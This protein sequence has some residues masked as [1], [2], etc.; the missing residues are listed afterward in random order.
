MMIKTANQIALFPKNVPYVPVDNNWA[1]LANRIITSMEP[2][3]DVTPLVI[4]IPPD[5]FNI[6]RIQVVSSDKKAQIV[7]SSSKID[8][9]VEE[10]TLDNA[11]KDYFAPLIELLGIEV[12]RIGV[13]KHF[14]GIQFSDTQIK[15]LFGKAVTWS[16]V[17]LEITQKTVENKKIDTYQVVKL[18]IKSIEK[19]GSCNVSIDINNI[20]NED[21]SFNKETTIDLLNHYASLAN[22]EQ[23][24]KILGLELYE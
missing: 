19:N 21:I 10:L 15:T 3:K 17:N 18:L 11:R 23:A 5:E 13:I 14:Q 16:D 4:P 20:P 6:P 8:M 1:N 24:G 22:L 2:F 7:I 9:L 12:L